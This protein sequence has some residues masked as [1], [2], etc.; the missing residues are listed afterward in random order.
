M[1]VEV[2]IDPGREVFVQLA[3]RLPVALSRTLHE[4]VDVDLHPVYPSWQMAGSWPLRP[5]LA[6]SSGATPALLVDDVWR[7]VARARTPDPTCATRITAA[8]GITNE[9]HGHLG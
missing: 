8:D 9:S 1:V 4:I 7:R 3:E 2:V 5:S 6:V